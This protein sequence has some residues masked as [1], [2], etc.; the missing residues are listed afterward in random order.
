M[1]T[2]GDAIHQKVEAAYQLR[3]EANCL[4]TEAKSQVKAFILGT[5]K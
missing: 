4:L 3:K 1:N 2:I 5:K